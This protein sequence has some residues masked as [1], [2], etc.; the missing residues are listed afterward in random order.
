MAEIS[1][2]KTVNAPLGDLW[3]S[4]SDLRLVHFFPSPG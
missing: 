2:T 1:V 3:A 4:W